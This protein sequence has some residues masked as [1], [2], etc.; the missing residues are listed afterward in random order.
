MN[1]GTLTLQTHSS[2]KA[3]RL[4]TFPVVCSKDGGAENAEWKMQE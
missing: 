1:E 4:L 3:Q 2:Y